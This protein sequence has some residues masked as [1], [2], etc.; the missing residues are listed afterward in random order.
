MAGGHSA[1]MKAAALAALATG[2]SVRAVARQFAVS[3]ATVRAWRLVAGGKPLPVGNPQK[4]ADLGE[5]LYGY[6]NESIAALRSQLR[7][8]GDEAWLRSQPAA[9]LGILHGIIADKTVRLLQAVRAEPEPDER[10]VAIEAA[11]RAARLG[12]G[13]R[14]AA[15]G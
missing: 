3:P 8:F 11:S 14:D 7:V 4:D 1:E 12:A 6:L 5:Q 9:D 13:A 15:D 2:S 10:P